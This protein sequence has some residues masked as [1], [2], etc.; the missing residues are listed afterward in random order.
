MQKDTQL[1]EEEKKKIEEE[2]KLRTKIREKE[3]KKKQSKKAI[4]CLVI[5]LL[6]VGFVIL[7]VALGGS[8]EKSS[9]PTT[10]SS[11]LGVGEEGVLNNN[12]DKN[13]V[14]GVAILAVDE[15]AFDDFTQASIAD[16]KLGYSQMLGAGRLFVVDNGTAVKVID[17]KFLGK[18]EVRV[19]EGD[20][21]GESGW[22]ASEFIVS[23]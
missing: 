16:D 23:K 8:G 17:I 20:Y 18:T 11:I 19:L 3:E 6:V 14:S 5:I 22:I 7:L 2:E 12:S 15:K 9:S 4:G 10:Q 13:D 1:T 21:F